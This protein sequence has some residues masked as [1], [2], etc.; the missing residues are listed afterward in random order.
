MMDASNETCCGKAVTTA[1]CPNC[2]KKCL[3][4]SDP[5]SLL[6][7]LENQRAKAAAWLAKS[8][9]HKRRRNER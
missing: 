4:P 1:Y 6:R 3:L 7:Y 5:R 2:G 9:G 8:E